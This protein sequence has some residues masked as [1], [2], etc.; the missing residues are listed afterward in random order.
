M[1]K[2][3]TVLKD[4][5]ERMI[6]EHHKTSLV[7]G[8]HIIRYNAARDLVKD[9]IVLDIACGSGYGSAVLAEGATKVYGVDI[10]EATVSYAKENYG[11]KN[12][13]Y[14]VGSA[15]KIPLPDN[16]VDVVVTYETIEHI[17]NYKKFLDETKRVLKKDG[18]LL[19]S[20]PNDVEFIEGNHFHIHEFEYKEL[21]DLLGSYYTNTKPW[22]QGDW[23]CSGILSPEQMNSE[24]EQ[25]ISIT[26][27]APKGVEQSIYFF[28]LC[29]D[30]KITE[31]VLPLFSLSE[32]WSTRGDQ[33]QKKT[34]YQEKEAVIRS[35]EIE[36]QELVNA[37]NE[38]NLANQE[39]NIIKSSR[40]WQL[41]E[42]VSKLQMRI[43][44]K[45]RRK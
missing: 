6:P 19:V 21:M 10:D 26:N 42:K 40:K 4:D 33:E 5:G 18:L 16:S 14:K 30:R 32:H 25:D 15:T 41:M 13:E 29:S 22:L 35:L 7:Y 1:T 31:E 38:L 3:K 20:T 28:V 39:L 11:R 12:I 44:N 45:K 43:N 27:V 34:H 24:W 8:E 37:N 23:L 9:R 2:N 36:N 17:K